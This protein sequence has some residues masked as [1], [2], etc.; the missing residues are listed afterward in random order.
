MTLTIIIPVYNESKTVLDVLRDV[1]HLALP[2][3][4]NKQ[5]I[6]VNDGSTDGSNEKIQSFAKKQKN[7]DYI[8]LQDNH[9]K[10]F[11]IREGLQKARGEYI[12]VQDADKEYAPRDLV[13][14]VDKML[15]SP[16]TVIYGDR[17]KRV[18]NGS[19]GERL[20]FMTHNIGNMGL[21][22]IT[23]LLYGRHLVD[24]A[25]CYK[26]FPRE[27]IKDITFTAEKFDFDTELTAHLLKIGCTFIS[28]PIS[29]TPR[30]YKDG[31][32]LNAIVEGPKA[33]WTLFRVRFFS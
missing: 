19:F 21:T 6:V 25:T 32:K 18:T 3:K 27:K 11:A 7:I 13:S 17:R 12:V 9:G 31:K 26:M 20:L 2:E 16:G 5:I 29:F 24:G 10:G 22:G 28:V 15:A 33:L 4:V 30:G 8:S 23:W 1:T 14:M